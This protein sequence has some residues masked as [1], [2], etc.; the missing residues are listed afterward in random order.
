[1]DKSGQF[2][3]LFSRPAIRYIALR[4]VHWKGDGQSVQANL[5]LGTTKTRLHKI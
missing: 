4:A 5:P 1:M 2:R 3:R